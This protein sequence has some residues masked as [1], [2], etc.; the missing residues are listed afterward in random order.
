MKFSL[1]YSDHGSSYRDAGTGNWDHSW[2]ESHSYEYHSAE[3]V[4]GGYGEVDL[5]PGDAEVEVGDEIYMVYVSYGTGDSFGHASGCHEHLWAFSDRKRAYRLAE[6]LEED[7]KVNPD[8]DY[9]HKPLEFEGVPINTN[10][11][12]GYFERFEEAGVEHLIVKKRR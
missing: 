2:E 7:A 1:N 10:S 4:T 11:W 6:V 8:Y 3:I 9:D 5:F 12:K